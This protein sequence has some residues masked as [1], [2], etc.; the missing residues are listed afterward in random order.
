[1]RIIFINRKKLGIIV[2]LMGLMITLLGISKG[3]DKQLKTTILVEH[4]INLLNDFHA[5]NGKVSYKLPEGWTTKEK[6]FSGGEIIYHNDFQSSDAVIHGFV[7]VWTSK[8]N[9]K[10]FLDNSKKISQEQNAIKN[11]K[12]DSVIINGKK[13]YLVQY[14]INVTDNN[15]YKVYEYFIDDGSEFYRFSFFTRNVNFK[16][17]FGAI[18]ESIVETFKIN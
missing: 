12:L 8:Q 15:W 9:L 4:N 3:F 2:I 14:L 6:K 7:E 1:M 13:T 16:E 11:Y 5:L 17:A 10:T 18:Y